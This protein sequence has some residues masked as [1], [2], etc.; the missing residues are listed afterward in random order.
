MKN[1][2]TVFATS[3]AKP[4]LLE[5]HQIS[6]SGWV[7]F[8]RFSFSINICIKTGTQHPKPEAIHYNVHYTMC[9]VQGS[10]GW[11]R[12]WTRFK[13]QL[14]LLQR[15]LEKKWESF[16]IDTCRQN[17]RPLITM[18]RAVEVGWGS[19]N[20]DLLQDRLWD[21]LLNIAF[22][23]WVLE[24]VPWTQGC[25]AGLSAQLSDRGLGGGKCTLVMVK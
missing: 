10:R 8:I 15:S 17:L 6:C 3:V 11:A 22:W 4:Y 19:E 12:E 24:L 2:Y 20:A 9:N 25:W 7:Q 5:L 18:Y 23:F 21:R 14:I 16:E 1:S 13:S